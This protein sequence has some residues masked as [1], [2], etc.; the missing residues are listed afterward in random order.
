[1]DG[2]ENFVEIDSGNV[3]MLWQVCQDIEYHLDI[4]DKRH[5]LQIGLL[6]V[7]SLHLTIIPTCLLKSC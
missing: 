5:S 1:M 2:I 4:P 6:N 3:E 7:S